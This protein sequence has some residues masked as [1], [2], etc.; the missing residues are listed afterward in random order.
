MGTIQFEKGA[1]FVLFAFNSF[2]NKVF[3]PE[4]LLALLRNVI[5]LTVSAY[6]NFLG[7][8]AVLC[9]SVV[10]QCVCQSRQQGCVYSAVF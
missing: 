10:F 7:P 3:Q 9:M 2:D 4:A 1:E 8:F 6:G 5:W